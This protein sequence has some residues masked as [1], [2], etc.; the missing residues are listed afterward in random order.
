VPS[1]TYIHA[2]SVAIFAQEVERVHQTV[3][4]NC[5]LS[6]QLNHRAMALLRRGSS[7]ISEENFNCRLKRCKAKRG[8]I[9]ASLAWNDPSD[10]DLHAHIVFAAGGEDTINYHKKQCGGG[11]LDVDMHAR[12]KE[13]VAEP[14][15]NIFWKNPPA[16][17]YSISVKQFKKR[18]DRAVDVPFRALLNREG[19][20]LLSVE[21]AVGTERGDL[22][23]CFRFIVDSE[24]AVTWRALEGAG[25]SRIDPRYRRETSKI[26]GFRPDAGS[27]PLPPAPSKAR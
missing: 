3:L 17:T 23:E 14:V 4:T 26:D 18:G 7:H 9:T 6:N 1:Y 2:Q 19:E 5:S 13:L 21:G 16:G 8:A 12:D 11:V 25:E 15:E 22:V 20:D 10:L 24:G 27:I